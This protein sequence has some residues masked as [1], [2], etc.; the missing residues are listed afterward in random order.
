[1]LCSP[2]GIGHHD[3]EEV[4]G[5]FAGVQQAIETNLVDESEEAVVCVRIHLSQYKLT[6]TRGEGKGEGG[7]RE[8]V[9]TYSGPLQNTSG[10]GRLLRCGRAIPPGSPRGLIGDRSLVPLPR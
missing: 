7:D 3:Q 9:A 5:S 10:E 8:A 1:M 6:L 2:H 4:L